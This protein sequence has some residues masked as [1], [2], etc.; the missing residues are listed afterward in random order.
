MSCQ[1]WSNARARLS[2]LNRMPPVSSAR[3][4]AGAGRQNEA[5]QIEAN[6]ATLLA[7]ADRDHPLVLELRRRGSMR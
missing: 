3:P 6:A 4:S 2:V 7:V 1:I 5:A